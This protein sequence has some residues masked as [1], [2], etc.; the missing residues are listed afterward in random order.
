MKVPSVEVVKVKLKAK[1]FFFH[2]RKS[3][4]FLPSLSSLGRFPFISCPI[5]KT[6]SERQSLQSEEFLVV[7]RTIVPIER[8]TLYSYSFDN[9][10]FGSFFD[11][12]YW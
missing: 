2:F 11:I 3:K 9:P 10:K 12:H 8:F 5:T 7:T 6:E 4:V 1:F